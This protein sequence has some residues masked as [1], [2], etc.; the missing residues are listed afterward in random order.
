[1]KSIIVL[2]VDHDSFSNDHPEGV[3]L[4]PD[5]LYRQGGFVNDD[6]AGMYGY[7]GWNTVY[8]ASDRLLNLIGEEATR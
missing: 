3:N 5:E 7:E 6:A 8:G 4:S 2:V 1:M